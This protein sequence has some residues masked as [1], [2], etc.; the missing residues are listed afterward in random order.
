MDKG[1]RFGT[2]RKFIELLPQREA[3]GNTLFR[4]TVIAWTMEQFGVT[5][6]AAATH[7]NHAFIEA[8]KVTPPLPLDG[9]GRPEDKKGG[10]KRKAVEVAGDFVDAEFVAPA[11]F[12]V[13]KKADNELL[14]GGLSFEDA[15]AMVS[16]GRNTKGHYCKMYWL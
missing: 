13:Y 3:M 1:I 16:K 11:T 2:D 15:Q 10:R 14:A 12:A 6:A 8:R 4:K 9:L 7:Y 5:L